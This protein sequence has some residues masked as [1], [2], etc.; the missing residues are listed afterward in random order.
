[1]K[2]LIAAW[3]FVVDVALRWY[4]GRVGDLAAGV[5]FWIVVSLPAAV[6]ALVAALAP[7]D[8]LVGL[9]L[10]AQIEETAVEFVARTFT[11]ERRDIQATV[12]ALFLQSNPSLLTV[13]LAVALWSISRGFAGL[14]RALD[15]IYEVDDGRAWYH[16]RVVALLLGLGSLLVSL[17][18]LALERLV[19]PSIPAGPAERVLRSVVVVTILALWAS[20]IYHY[21]PSRRSRWHH[22]LPG[23]VA[24]AVM[25]W[26]LSVGFGFYVS[27]TSGANDVTAA[28]GAGLLALTWIWL[29]AQVLLIGGTINV[30][31]GHRRSILRER[32]TWNLN[33]RITGEIRRIVVPDRTR[34]GDRRQDPDRRSGVDR[35]SSPRPRST[36]PP[37]R[38]GPPTVDEETI[39]VGDDPDRPGDGPRGTVS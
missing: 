39:L 1:M 38:S 27:V 19:W 26:L 29:A 10:K 12:Q 23:A 32:R 7:L 18:L 30:L 20:T 25:W 15:D 9:S 6:L 17:P 36:G 24:A 33:D 16:T 21:G 5:T 35:R 2:L 8:A 11:D 22:D 34:N 13:S 4:Y 3:R 14:I 37:A 31:Y 28:I